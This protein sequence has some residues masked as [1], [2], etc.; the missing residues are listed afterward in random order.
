[1]S[2]AILG[3][4]VVGSGAYEVLKNAGYTVKRVLDIRPHEELGDILTSNFDDILND[5]EIGIVAEAIGG[6][7]IS[8]KFVS[9]ALAAGKHVVSSNKHL[10]C[11]YYEELLLPSQ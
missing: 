10:I 2:I 6:V 9:A 3:Y 8:Y 4:G 1:M 5:D 11:T 7:S